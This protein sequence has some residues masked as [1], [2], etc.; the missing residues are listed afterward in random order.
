M[1]RKVNSGGGLAGLRRNSGYVMMGGTSREVAVVVV[2]VV[3]EEDVEEEEED[4]GVGAFC[5]DDVDDDDGV[6]EEDDDA[7]ELDSEGVGEGV[8]S[9]LFSWLVASALR[10]TPRSFWISSLL[11]PLDSRKAILRS[12]GASRTASSRRNLAACSRRVALDAVSGASW[13]LWADAAEEGW[14]G[15]AERDRRCQSGMEGPWEPRP[16]IVL[17]RAVDEALQHRREEERRWREEV[18]GVEMLSLSGVSTTALHTCSTS[19]CGPVRSPVT[20]T[21]PARRYLPLLRNAAAAEVLCLS[22]RYGVIL[23][24]R[25]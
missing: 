3:A 16:A 18:G 22:I 7:S 21:S 5:D 10:V 15:E 13:E 8:W 17:R 19:A 20:R 23:V 24:V 25:V 14:S 11:S 1:L 4:A 12:V 9:S 6:S 2:V